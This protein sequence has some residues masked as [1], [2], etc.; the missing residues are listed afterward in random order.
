MWLVSLLFAS[1][2]IALGQCMNWSPSFPTD[3]FGVSVRA[4]ATFDDGSGSALY[5]G[6]DFLGVVKWNGVTWTN[7]GSTDDA[8]SAL[9]VFDD[10]SGPALYAG[11]LFTNISGVPARALA[12]WDGS[13]W[14]EVGGGVYRNGGQSV[15]T[16]AAHDDGTGPALYVGGAFDV[17]GGSTT[18]R[19][20]ARWDGT[21][22][23]SFGTGIDDVALSCRCV[24]A[25]EW[26]D[27]GSGETLYAGGDFT[28]AGGIQAPGLARWNGVRW[29][30]VGNLVHGGVLTMAVFDDGTGPA[31]YAGGG[32]QPA[33]MSL[34][35]I[36]R[37]NGSSWSSVGGGTSCS[38]YA[39]EVFDDG[40]GPALYAGGCFTL[41]GSSA[42]NR[43]AR[44]DGST[45]SMLGSGLNADVYAMARHDDAGGVPNLCL[46]GAFDQ[47]GAI[48]SWR[49]AEWRGCTTSVET[50]CS[51]DGT[52]ASCP[53]SN[54]GLFAHGCENS[55]GTGG[56]RLSTTGS[57][58]PDSLVLHTAEELPSALSIVVQGDALVPG[59][60][61]FGDGLRCVGGHLK[62]LYTRTAVNGR[63]NVP[64]G[65]DPSITARSAALGDPLGLGVTR[66]YQV[67][68]RDSNPSYCA[69]PA[70]G[71]FNASN[72][73]RV[74][75]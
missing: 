41:A 52:V 24:A 33:G 34:Q 56:A 48:P 68:Y 51:G 37:W 40:R 64:I 72:G 8:V 61:A 35:F 63:V 44:W 11:G 31:L 20:I 13:Q 7:I 16:L 28:S 46:G 17:A 9:A 3:H 15:L 62:R 2:S 50:L 49:I 70:G 18:S 21:A 38:V 5:V 59:A 66:Y 25:L 4:L 39:L 12:K 60:A 47:A 14:S 65:Q 53:C 57:T 55:I 36:V 58:S 73:L 43:V 27:D 45:W 32:F 75:W 54:Q 19:G 26:F 71:T 69:A 67:Q 1:S 23:S 42:T 6:G 22:W 30:A 29:S 10:G 74:V